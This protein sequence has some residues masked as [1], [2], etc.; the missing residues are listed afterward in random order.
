V[1]FKGTVIV[2][3][4]IPK[5]DKLFRINLYK[6]CDYT[7]YAYDMTVCLG[8]GGKCATPSLTAALA[9]VTGLTARIENV[10]HSL[11]MDNFF[12]SP[13]LFYDLLVKMIKCCG[14]LDQIENGCQKIL[15]V[16]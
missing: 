11:Y 2:R 3:Q 9:T 15:D 6:L 4:Y 5:R 7:E 12:L 8:K 13:E 1:L 14:L 10:G 16:N